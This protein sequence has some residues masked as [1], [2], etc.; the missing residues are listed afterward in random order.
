MA[1][2]DRAR[3]AL[4]AQLTPRSLTERGRMV[5]ELLLAFDEAAVFPWE[6]LGK[7]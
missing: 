7:R 1:H 2:R 6:T 4:A 5:G 3:R